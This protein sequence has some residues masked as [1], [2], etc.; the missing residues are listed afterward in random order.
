MHSMT[1]NNTYSS[2][3]L[4]LLSLVQNNKS[5][6]PA[7]NHFPFS[8]HADTKTNLFLR[9]LQAPNSTFQNPFHSHHMP[10]FLLQEASLSVL[11]LHLRHILPLHMPRRH[12]IQPKVT[13]YLL[14]HPLPT[15]SLK[16]PT[17]IVIVSFLNSLTRSVVTL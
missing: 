4:I 3:L 8:P 11:I 10:P 14:I 13:I 7:H 9:A 6:F 15:I 17:S 12:R 16:S 5:S 1:C 2:P